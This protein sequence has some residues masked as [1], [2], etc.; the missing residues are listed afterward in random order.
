MTAATL[1]TSRD[2]RV[3]GLVSA[4]HLMS[5]FYMM[6]LPPL[7]PLLRGEMGVSNTELGFVITLAAIAAGVGQMPT[8]IVVDR[9]GAR[10]VLIGG[11]AVMAATV[12]LMGVAPGYAW[13]P[14]LAVFLGLAN[15]VFHP[16]DYA[17]LSHAV[18]SE[19]VGR[20]YSLHTFSG[21]LGWT[22]A[23]VLMTAL[24][25]FWGWRAALIGAAILGAAVVVALYLGRDHLSSSGGRKDEA[26]TTPGT[27]P[28]ATTLSILVH[29]GILVMFCYFIMNAMTTVGLNSFT[30]TALHDLHGLD[31][32]A[33]NAGLTAFLVGACSGVLAGGVIA[34]RTKRY[35]LV[36]A[37]G[38]IASSSAVLAIAFVPVG[39]L[40]SVAALGTAGFMLGSI[41]PSRDMIVRSLTPAGAS[42]R[43]FGFLSVG[44]EIGAAVSPTL[45]GF[46]IDQGRPELVFV[47][48]AGFMMTAMLG[49]TTAAVLARRR[50]L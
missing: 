42:G 37:T 48:C 46:I 23:P 5:H 25:A 1:P 32:V 45:F 30:A 47:L 50:P 4:G 12:G 28:S 7:F 15:A 11:V 14:V 3:I 17:I 24:A 2:V 39:T 33:A 13:L 22:A 38:F 36:A 16:A 10:W 9:F 27:A 6:A 31:F 29:P 21:Y 18:R 41:L 34:D 43:V 8:G 26:R 35:E 40:G 44:I 49:A 19:R 20:A